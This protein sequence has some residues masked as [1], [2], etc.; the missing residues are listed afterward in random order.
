MNGGLDCRSPEM[1]AMYDNQDFYPILF[2][3]DQADRK[4]MQGNTVAD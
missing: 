4:T 3:P 2:R 1:L